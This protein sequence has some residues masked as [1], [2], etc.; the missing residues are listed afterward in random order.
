MTTIEETVAHNHETNGADRPSEPQATRVTIKGIITHAGK[1]HN[2]TQELGFVRIGR[3]DTLRGEYIIC[4]DPQWYD[5]KL[6][7]GWAPGAFSVY[8]VGNS[9]LIE[10]QKN[11]SHMPDIYIPE[12]GV[13]KVDGYFEQ[14]KCS[15]IE[16]LPQDQELERYRFW[17][18]SPDWGFPS[19]CSH[20]PRDER[21]GFLLARA[22]Q[23]ALR[24]YYYNYYQ[25]RK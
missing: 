12:I 22:Q 1:L 25:T 6:I 10:G 4:K 8:G 3:D 21:F 20:L 23:K 2:G 11:Q 14:Y 15:S 7:S 9:M 24:E 17:S 16:E 5:D 19:T 13:E 18:F